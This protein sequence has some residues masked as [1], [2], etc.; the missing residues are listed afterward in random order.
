[1]VYAARRV[2]AM[3]AIMRES[4]HPP[5]PGTRHRPP[6][7]GAAPRGPAIEASLNPIVA[8]EWRGFLPRL[9]DW[10]LWIGLRLPRQPREWGLPAISWYVLAPYVQWVLLL[11]LFRIDP[12]M[13]A[14][15]TPGG[16]F[17]IFIAGLGWYA[18][19]VAAAIG[20]ATITRERERGTWEQLAVTPMTR[21]D[22][23]RGYWLAGA[24]PLAAGVTISVAG[25][26]L[27]YPHYLG[28]L[29]SLG[30]FD[31][32]R[33]ELLRYGVLLT[34]RVIAFTALGIA[35]SSACGRTA[36]A[37]AVS[38]ASAAFILV[39][40]MGVVQAV[41]PG[42]SLPASGQYERSEWAR[43]IGSWFLPLLG[44]AA[45]TCYALQVATVHLQE[46]DLSS[47]A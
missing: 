3:A 18:C 20:A 26:L 43:E 2:R 5:S 28:L 11:I 36:V 10:R 32:E 46:E 19:G 13:K 24:L 39:A 47:V 30:R 29:E 45:L 8:R 17:G 1:V 14:F 9:R 34:S 37:T 25:W 12:W 6:L 42:Y 44:Y 15:I 22:L 23:V 16:I 38:V 41:T 31:V 21:W 35:L 27:L 4:Y 40:E 7:R 33:G